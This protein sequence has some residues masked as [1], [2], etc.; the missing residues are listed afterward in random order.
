MAF[1][2]ASMTSDVEGM[3]RTLHK[4]EGKE[5]TPIVLLVS[6]SQMRE[7]EQYRSWGAFARLVKPGRSPT[8]SECWNRFTAKRRGSQ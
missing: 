8:Y 5:K 6:L 1:I 3:L 2:D 7:L 4:H